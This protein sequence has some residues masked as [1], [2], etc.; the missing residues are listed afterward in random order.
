MSEIVSETKKKPSGVTGFLVSGTDNQLQGFHFAACL[1]LNLIEQR[2]QT[3]Y[4]TCFEEDRETAIKG[5][6]QLGVT[7][8]EIKYKGNRETYEMVVKGEHPGWEARK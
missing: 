7:M 8:Q 1:V 6:K 4:Y 5:A 3:V 2:G